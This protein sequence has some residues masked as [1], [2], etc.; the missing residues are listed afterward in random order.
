MRAQ[1]ARLVS[2]RLHL[3]PPNRC[4]PVGDFTTH[5]ELPAQSPLADDIAPRTVGC[6]PC[7]IDVL[8]SRTDVCCC[9]C[10]CPC[11]LLLLL[12]HHSRLRSGRCF[13][14]LILTILILILFRLMLLHA[15]TAAP[16]WPAAAPVTSAADAWLATVGVCTGTQYRTSLLCCPAR[17]REHHPGTRRGRG[18]M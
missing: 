11:E 3:C 14:L 1:G 10:R 16:G 2:S 8:P 18:G 5:Y 13:S 15:V 4:S 17:C 6:C 12:R 9:C 7:R